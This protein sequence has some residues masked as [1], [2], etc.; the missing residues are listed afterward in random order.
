[1]PML[2]MYLIEEDKDASSSSARTSCLAPAMGTEDVVL[3]TTKSSSDDA[4]FP[5]D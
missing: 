5:S 2:L 3:D 1:M 4:L